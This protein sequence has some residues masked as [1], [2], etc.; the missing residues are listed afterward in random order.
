MMSTP[1]ALARIHDAPPAVTGGRKARYPVFHLMAG[2]SA[3]LFCILFLACADP[4]LAALGITGKL[5]DKPGNDGRSLQLLLHHIAANRSEAIAIQR[6]LV[7]RPAIVPEMGGQ[8]EDEKARWIEAWL[9]S[10]S[11]PAA[12]RVDCPDERVPAK[13]RPNLIMRHPGATGRTLWIFGHLDVSPSGPE[14]MWTGSP[15]ALRVDG[16]RLYGRGVEDNNQSIVNGLLLLEALHKQAVTPPVGL[17]LLY[18]SGAKYGF[19]KTY[20]LEHVLEARPDIF[21]PG[22]MILLNDY[23]NAQGSIVE[24]AEKGLLSLRVVV[25]GKQIHAAL[26]HDRANALHAGA[27]IISRLP[28]LAT[29]FPKSDPLFSPPVSTFT[30]TLVEAGTASY[31]QVPGLFVF[32]LDCRFVP[33]YSPEEV[34]AGIRLLADSVELAHKVAIQLEVKFSIPAAPVTAAVSPVVMALHRALTEELALSA[35]PMGNGASTM[36]APLRNRGWPVAVWAMADSVGATANEYIS[37]SSHL[38]SAR[39]F[40]RMLYDK[41]VAHIIMPHAAKEKKGS[42]EEQP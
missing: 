40:A 27:E 24:L 22:D 42:R 13:V 23:G 18:L 14:D 3:L 31:S 10:K 35:D 29:S 30:A 1:L 2:V 11:L 7:K 9:S 28:E 39:I 4:C 34:L 21:R 17:G 26:E 6:E 12:E 20:G 32:H 8:G 19:P 41:D 36:A 38:R 33:G 15:W 37:L 16:D 25:Q 5:P